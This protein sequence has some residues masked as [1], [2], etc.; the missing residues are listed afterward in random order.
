MA[1]DDLKPAARKRKSRTSPSRRLAKN[2]VMPREETIVATTT[3]TSPK[4][5]T[6]LI[7]RTNQ[8]DP[9]DPPDPG[10]DKG[11]GR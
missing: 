5:K 3:V 7:V 9:Y 2:P 4:G 1:N 10:R 11:K 6:Y 8:R